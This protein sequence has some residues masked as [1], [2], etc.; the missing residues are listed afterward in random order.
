MKSACSHSPIDLYQVKRLLLTRKD[1]ETGIALDTTSE[2]R[3]EASLTLQHNGVK[4]EL[5]R[6]GHFY[7]EPFFLL[8]KNRSLR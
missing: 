6:K 5:E 8:S 1:A 7:S 4:R 3:K 2:A